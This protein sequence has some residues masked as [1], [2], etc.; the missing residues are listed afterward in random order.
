MNLSVI[1]LGLNKEDISLGAYNHLKTAKTVVLRTENTVS[2]SALKDWGI[3]YVALDYVYQK[4]KNFDS[5]T[6]NICAEINKM[7][8]L[9]D[10]CYL[11]D[12]AVSEDIC[13]AR[14]LKRHKKAV[15]FEGV[16]KAAAAI[17]RMGLCGQG[18]TAASAYQFDGFDKFTLPL[19]VYDLDSQ[20]MASEWKLKLSSLIGEEAKVGL[21]VDNRLKYVNMYEIDSFKN[22]DYSTVLVVPDIPLKDRQRFDFKDL[23]NI[24]EILRG[25]NGCP[26]DRVQTR[27]SL[28]K[29]LIEEAYELVDAVNK[30]DEDKI[31]EETGDLLL[32]GAFYIALSKEQGF[33]DGNDVL[34][35]ICTKLILR[36]SHVFGG[37]KAKN[38]D[39]AL[40]IW[41]KNKQVEKHLEDPAKY[42]GDVPKSLPA[43]L[44]AEKT[45]KRIKGFDKSLNDKAVLVEKITKVIKDIEGGCDK[46]SYKKLLIYVVNLLSVEDICAEDL[47]IDATDELILFFANLIETVGAEALKNKGQMSDY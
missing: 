35:G 26:W 7:L 27:E 1:G 43:L 20:I 34:S 39:E 22:Y 44:R 4:S 38:A 16:S 41:N 3:D 45:L 31:C 5:L 19:V 10:V 9:G 17:S 30:A 46:E 2:C 29:T 25:D 40:T 12:G 15:V 36:H 21:Y 32:Q 8:K 28:K 42:V 11:V 24:V 23:V 37:D 18:Y 33:Y 14:L 6:K 13:A 47:A